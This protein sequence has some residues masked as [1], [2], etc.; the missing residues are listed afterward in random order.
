MILP[1]KH[2]RPERAL[3]GVGGEILG[4]LSRPMTVSQLW[5]YIRTRR[6]ITPSVPVIDYRWFVLTLDFLYLIGVVDFQQG[7]VRRSKPEGRVDS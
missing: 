5:N 3:I 2:L 7:L 1:T 6:E 4:I